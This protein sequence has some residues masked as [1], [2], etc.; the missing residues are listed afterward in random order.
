MLTKEKLLEITIEILDNGGDIE[1]VSKDNYS[2][3][4]KYC[5]AF[6]DGV[7]SLYERIK[8]ELGGLG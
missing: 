3:E 1:D 8:D 4:A 6:N 2:E 5:Y 7:M